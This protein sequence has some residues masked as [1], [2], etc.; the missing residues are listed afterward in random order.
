MLTT[1]FGN[2]AFSISVAN[3]RSGAGPSSEAFSTTVQPAASAGAELHG[4]E[5]HLRVPRHQRGHDADRLAAQRHVHVGLVDR[6]MRALQLV[7]EPT[8]IAV[9][10]RH[11]ADLGAGL[12]DDLAGVAGF[13]LGEI[14]GVLGHEIAEPQQQL[15]PGGRRKVGPGRIVQGAM[16]GLDGPVHVLAAGG[17]HHGPGAL[18]RGIE[19]FEG[20][21]GV[22]EG[23]VDEVLEAAK[24]HRWPP[25]AKAGMTRRMNRSRDFFFRS[26][27]MPESIQTENW[28]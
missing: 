2:P 8:E 14:L 4:G 25:H 10:V 6:Q 28:S 12:A 5:E 27:L 17:R 13:Q 1:P 22:A 21:G 15:A 23:A 20:L 9:V 3:S 24:A 7:G 11:I 18:G 26:W 16:R 19:A